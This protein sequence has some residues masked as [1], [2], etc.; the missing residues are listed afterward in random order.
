[1][2][3]QTIHCIL[4]ELFEELKKFYSIHHQDYIYFSG[5]LQFFLVPRIRCKFFWF[6][7][8]EKTYYSKEYYKFYQSFSQIINTISINIKNLESPLNNLC[9]EILI[10]IY[11]IQLNNIIVKVKSLG[12]VVFL[13]LIQI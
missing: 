9:E 2:K 10:L 5:V 7:Y 3:T 13:F 12:F 8:F 6:S 1:M 4:E 11:T